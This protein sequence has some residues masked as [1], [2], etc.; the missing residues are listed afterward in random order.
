MGQ[1]SLLKIYAEI[2]DLSQQPM[3]NPQFP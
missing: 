1:L 3:Y 2:F